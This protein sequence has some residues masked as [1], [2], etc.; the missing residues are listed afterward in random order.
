VDELS[1]RSDGFRVVALSATPGSEISRVQQVVSKLR[2]SHLEV[3]D[4]TDEDV[5]QYVHAKR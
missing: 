3:R 5:R 4:E 2:V 1:F